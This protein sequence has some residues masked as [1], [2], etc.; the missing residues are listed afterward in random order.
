MPALSGLFQFLNSTLNL[1]MS[2]MEAIWAVEINGARD[3]FR[4]PWLGVYLFDCMAH[5]QFR[6]E[7]F[8]LLGRD[9]PDDFRDSFGESER[10][11]ALKS[12]LV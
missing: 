1:F 8:I 2:D 3:W 7:I 9:R 6:T 5:V 12:S 11:V 10:G 4:R